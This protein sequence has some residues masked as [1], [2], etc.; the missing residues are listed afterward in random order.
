M[1]A[2]VMVTVM[3]V[4]KEGVSVREPSNAANEFGRR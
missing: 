3:M 2:A 1:M 4:E